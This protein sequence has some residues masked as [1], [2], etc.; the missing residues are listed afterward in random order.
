[1]HYAST[2]AGKIVNACTVLHNMCIE[3]NLPV[4]EIEDDVEIDFGMYEDHNNYA[5][6]QGDVN[7][8]AGRRLQNTIINN[9][10]GHI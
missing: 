8:V 4:P 9:Y 3:N 5:N 1:M 10:F 6:V 7:L 2:K